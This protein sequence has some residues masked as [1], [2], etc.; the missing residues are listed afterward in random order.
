MQSLWCKRTRYIGSIPATIFEIFSPHK[1]EWNQ[2]SHLDGIILPIQVEWTL[3]KWIL[4]AQIDWVNVVNVTREK[5][6]QTAKHYWVFP[7]T[8]F[9]PWWMPQPWLCWLQWRHA[10]DEIETLWH[11][12]NDFE[13]RPNP[14]HL[15]ITLVAQNL[16]LLQQQKILLCYTSLLPAKIRQLY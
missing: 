10:R 2:R 16:I 12:F 8:S 15:V 11:R 4:L 13:N 3:E 6:L 5:K 14:S 7:R 9:E 1:V